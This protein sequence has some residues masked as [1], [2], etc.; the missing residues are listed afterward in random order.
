M[1][2]STCVPNDAVP[3]V[4]AERDASPMKSQTVTPS[5]IKY[6]SNL[7]YDEKWNVLL[8]A[9]EFCIIAEEVRYRQDDVDVDEDIVWLATGESLRKR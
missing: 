7:T 2:V 4:P 1:P 6:L 5:C 9:L 8:N 3:K